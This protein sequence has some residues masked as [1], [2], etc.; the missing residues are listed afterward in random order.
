MSDIEVSGQ[1]S[2]PSETMAANGAKRGRGRPKKDNTKAAAK[3]KMSS[4][5]N[6]VS[7]S[8]GTNGSESDQTSTLPK[9]RGRKPRS[10]VENKEEKSVTTKTAAKRGRG[11]P[12][13]GRAGTPKKRGRKAAKKVSDSEDDDQQNEDNTGDEDEDN[14]DDNEDD[15]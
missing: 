3:P 10:V 15:D 9:K 14:A 5:N 2:S 12:K 6:G 4:V 13:K 8:N 11:R 1:Q 7:Q